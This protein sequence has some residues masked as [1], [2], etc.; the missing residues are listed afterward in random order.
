MLADGT[1][2]LQIDTD[3]GD[4]DLFIGNPLVCEQPDVS[5]TLVD[6]RP[7]RAAFVAHNPTDAARPR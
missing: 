2:F 5:L 4:K 6:V 7:G 1:G 3:V